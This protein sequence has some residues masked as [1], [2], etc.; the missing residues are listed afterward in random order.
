MLSHFYEILKKYFFIFQV[1][2]IFKTKL[3]NFPVAEI[4]SLKN[5]FKKLRDVT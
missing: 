5:S 2:L 4:L 3:K 1:R